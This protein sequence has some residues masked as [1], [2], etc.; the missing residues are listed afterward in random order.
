[1]KYEYWK[2]PKNDQWYWRCKGGNGEP[3][4]QSEGY[5]RKE[6]CL[7]AISLLKASANAPVTDITP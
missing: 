1:M 4:A 7:A 6:S 5:A 2:S 3:I